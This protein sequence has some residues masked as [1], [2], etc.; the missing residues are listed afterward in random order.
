MVNTPIETGATTTNHTKHHHHHHHS[1]STTSSPPPVSSTPSSINDERKTTDVFESQ[2]C[3]NATGEKAQD[4]VHYLMQNYSRYVLI[5]QNMNY[6]L[7]IKNNLL[8]VF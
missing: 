2:E 7:F 4:L 6:V 8:R 3:M 1:E 5:S